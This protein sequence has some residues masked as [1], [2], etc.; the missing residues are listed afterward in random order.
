MKKSVLWSLVLLLVFGF[1]FMNDSSKSS[2]GGYVYLDVNNLKSGFTNS[3]VFNRDTTNVA[4]GLEWPKASGKFVCFTSGLT[5]A[6][7][8]NGQFAMT[9]GSYKGEYAPGYV[10]NGHYATNSNFKFYK[11]TRGDNSGTNPDWANW[12]LMVPYGAPWTDVNHNGIYDPSVDTPGVHGASQTIFICLTDADS[13]SH[14]IG[15]GFG[16]GIKDP[17]MLSE[18]HLT[19]W[20]YTKNSIKDVQ[21][22]KYEVINKNTVAWDSTILSII[23]DPDL[24]TATDDYIGCDTVRDMPYCYNANPTDLIYGFAPPAYGMMFL[25]GM[26]RKDVT[27]NVNLGM[28][29]SNYFT[30]TG[31]APPPCE[32][33]PNGEPIPAYNIMK[34]FKKDLTWWLNPLASGSMKTKFTYPGSPETNTGWTESKGSILNCGGDTNTIYYNTPNIAGD[35]RFTINSGP[36]KVN[37][38]DTQKIIVAQMVARGITNRNSVGNLRDLAD[39]AIAI[40]NGG[41]NVGIIPVNNSVPALLNLHQNYPNPFNPVTRIKFDVPNMS[42]PNGIIGNPV[43]LKVFDITG[44]EVSTLIN[45]K[46][47]PGSYEVTFDGSN[48]NSGIYFYQLISGN[49]KETRKLILLK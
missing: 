18:V 11:V 1:A 48:L 33:D 36:L 23:S 8:I 35:R 21:F 49:F 20:A 7:Y 26:V 30:N 22:I 25:Q 17:L 41:F 34:G 42:S 24:G 27:P 47:Q 16:G 38:G 6:C 31:S 45:E 29:A 10:L 44:R 46:L 39:T 3:G 19:A 5:M 28:T 37:P 15:E 9:A 13:S 12:G 4:C 32:S 40:Y 14:D 2:N 43:L